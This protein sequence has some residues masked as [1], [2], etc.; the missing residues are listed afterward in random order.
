MSAEASGWLDIATMWH[1]LAE[2][3]APSDLSPVARAQAPEVYRQMSDQLAAIAAA[4]IDGLAWPGSFARCRG[5]TGRKVP[6]GV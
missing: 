6:H 4:E 2:G 3:A 1:D 5:A